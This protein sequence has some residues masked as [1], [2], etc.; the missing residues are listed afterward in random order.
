[1]VSKVNND[2]ISMP[3]DMTIQEDEDNNTLIYHFE[4]FEGPLDLLLTLITKNKIDIQDISISDLLDQY[5]HQIELMKQADMDIAS[6]FLEMASRLL[7]IK[8]VMLLPRYDEKGED[9]KKELA[10]QLIEYALCKEIA[11]GFKTMY[12]FDT[13]CKEPSAIDFDLTYN[14][15]HPQTDI[16]HAYI[17]AVG[18]GKRKLPPNEKSFDGIVKRKVVSVP[19]KIISVMRRLWH[20]NRVRYGELFAASQGRSDLV[21]TFLAV[22]E[23]VKGKRIRI[24]G[25]GYEAEVYML[26]DNNDR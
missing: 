21:A 3:L 2:Q 17:S 15:I 13:F 14:R 16:M 4:V 25:N 20:G 24:D 22:L 9:L 12:D 5:M 11:L 23:L 26:E 6:E 18:R 7:Y 8:S 1:M 10:G 19:S